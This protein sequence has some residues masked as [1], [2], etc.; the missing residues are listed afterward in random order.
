MKGTMTHDRLPLDGRSLSFQ[1][2]NAGKMGI[3]LDL[4]RP[5]GQAIV[6]RLAE[7]AD[8]LGESFT[9]AA[10][11]RWNLHY[12]AL[13]QINPRLIYLSTCLGGQ[14][15]PYSTMAG[16][17][18]LSAA[19]AGFNSLCGWPDRA[20]AG[21]NGYYTD[22][23]TP[24]F[25]VTAVLAALH[26]RDQTGAG[27]H[28]DIAQAEAPVHFLT[29]AILDYEVNGRVVE[30]DGNRSEDKAP[31]GVFPCLGND[32]WVALA[33]E[34][35]V[36]WARLCALIGRPELANDPRFDSLA[37]RKRNEDELEREV[38]NWTSQM[39]AETVQE[40]LIAAGIAAHI[41]SDARDLHNDPQLH[42]RNHWVTV[43]H[44][45]LG[46]L[47]VESTLFKLSRT[48]GRTLSAAPSIGQHAFEVL[49]QFAGYSEDEI[50]DFAAA[51]VL[52]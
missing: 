25:V 35:D 32:R 29:P 44:A 42:H 37:R 38:T 23:V 6:R 7:W 27:Q 19:L 48:P 16:Y 11:R 22:Y 36:Q 52:Q 43:P 46:D 14:F 47:V 31:H 33:V 34:D 30:A 24:P 40:R 39:A 17:G 51:G 18:N 50:A 49:S 10:M 2:F 13:R 5:E 15:G 12:E 3:A 41:V 4:G 28:I 26:H 45:T 9:P 1:D 8:V 21:P 20:P